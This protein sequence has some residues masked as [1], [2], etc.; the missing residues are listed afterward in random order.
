MSFLHKTTKTFAFTL[1]I[2]LTGCSTLATK[3]VAIGCQVA[4]IVTTYRALHM[5][6]VELNPIPIPLLLAIKLGLIVWIWKSE[7]WDKESK[8]TRSAVSLLGCIPAI[9]N[10]KVTR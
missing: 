2:L 3:E 7:T 8:V 4:D 9:N 1:A 5:G 6:A 10:I